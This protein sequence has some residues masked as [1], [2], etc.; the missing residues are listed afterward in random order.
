MEEMC[1]LPGEGTSEPGCCQT[2]ETSVGRGALAPSAAEGCASP[3]AKICKPQR[4]Q[5]AQTLSK[6]FGSSQQNA[7]INRAQ[8]S[9][10]G[11]RRMRMRKQMGAGGRERPEISHPHMVSNARTALGIS[12]VSD[13]QGVPQLP[14]SGCGCSCSPL[15]LLHLPQLSSGKTSG[16]EVGPPHVGISPSMITTTQQATEQVPGQ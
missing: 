2:S 1:R 4:C 6:L 14:L 3:T 16:R 12:E 7:T 8:P 11:W 9:S 10:G 13:P 5:G 15:L